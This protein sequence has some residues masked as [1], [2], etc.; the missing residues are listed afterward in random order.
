M[1]VA[2]VNPSPSRTGRPYCHLIKVTSTEPGAAPD[3][4]DEIGGPGKATP[5]RSY[6]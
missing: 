3:E 5:V 2:P 6:D 1:E 4:G